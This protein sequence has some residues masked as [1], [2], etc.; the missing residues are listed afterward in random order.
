[1]T[2]V[3]IL[4]SILIHMRPSSRQASRSGDKTWKTLEISV[5]DL[6]RYINI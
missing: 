5:E 1:M 6:A 4:S 3:R 2:L